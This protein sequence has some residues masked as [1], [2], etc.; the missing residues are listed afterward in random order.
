[1]PAVSSATGFSLE[2]TIR[3][4]GWPVLTSGFLNP[5]ARILVSV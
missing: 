4:C 3:F 5:A 1:M 2:F